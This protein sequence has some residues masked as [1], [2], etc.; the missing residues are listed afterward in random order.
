MLPGAL[1]V[2]NTEGDPLVSGAPCGEPGLY[3]CG[4][5]VSPAAQLREIGTEANRIARLAK[6]SAR[7]G[8][9]LLVANEMTMLSK[10]SALHRRL[11]RLCGS[12]E[13]QF[14]KHR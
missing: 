1:D 5:T 12:P 10:A 7:P 11:K 4:T 14:L 3:F 2:L 9:T 8:K 6:P 13:L